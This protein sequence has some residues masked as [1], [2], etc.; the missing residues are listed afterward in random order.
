MKIKAL[1]S[2]AHKDIE[3][4]E[5]KLDLFKPF[6]LNCRLY[7]NQ[8]SYIEF[9]YINEEDMSLDDFYC[10]CGYVIENSIINNKTVLEK[11]K[12][13]YDYL[14]QNEMRYAEKINY[15]D[16]TPAAILTRAV[17]KDEPRANEYEFKHLII[18]KA[19]ELGYRKDV[20]DEAIKLYK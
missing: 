16:N 11:L 15:A 3:K 13:A 4:E 9:E 7:I 2:V 10:E 5:I 17:L 20:I 8:F 12:K 18:D 19:F 1:A 6:Q 14:M